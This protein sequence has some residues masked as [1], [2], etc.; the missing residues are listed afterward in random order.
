[1]DKIADMARQAARM[2]PALDIVPTKRSCIQLA[3]VYQLLEQIEALARKEAA[4]DGR[5]AD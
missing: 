2:L 5:K 3:S 4:S 1:M